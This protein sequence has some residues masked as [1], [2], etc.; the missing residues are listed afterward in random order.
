M[1]ELYNESG[2]LLQTF[3]AMQ[4]SMSYGIDMSGYP[5]GIYFFHAHTSNVSAVQKI[6]KMN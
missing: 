3:P 5:A 1:G 4:P 6:V 2:Q